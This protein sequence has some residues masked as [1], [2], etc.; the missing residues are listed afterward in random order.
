MARTWRNVAY[1][2]DESGRTEAYVQAYPTGGRW[3]AST[4]GGAEPRW[5]SGGR[6][7]IYRV[8]PT[9]VAVPVTLQPFTWGTAKTLFGLPNMFA[10]D[11]TADGR[12]FV[13]GKTRRTARASASCS[14]PGGSKSSRPGCGR[15]AETCAHGGGEAVPPCGPRGHR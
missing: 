13:I 10:F 8:G 1:Q 12:R 4:S 9:L 3:Q 11:V 7:L 14:F 15:H 5:T 6:E 2:S